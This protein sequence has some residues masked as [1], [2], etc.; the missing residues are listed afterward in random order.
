MRDKK[1]KEQTASLIDQ[2]DN[3]YFSQAGFIPMEARYGLAGDRE[4]LC[5]SRNTPVP[6]SRRVAR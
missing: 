4:S 3:F 2:A 5:F 1:P 6:K